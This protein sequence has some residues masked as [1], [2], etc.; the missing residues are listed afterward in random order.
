MIN[1][2]YNLLNDIGIPIDHGFRP[3]FNGDMVLSY[4]IFGEG[5]LKHGDGIATIFGGGLQIDLFVKHGID[6][7]DTKEKIKDILTKKSFKLIDINT[8]SENVDGIGKL[9]HIVFKF[10]Y[11]E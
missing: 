3:D 10:N 7:I 8:E 2:V 4:H 1:I 9:D 6:Y 11:K 5:A